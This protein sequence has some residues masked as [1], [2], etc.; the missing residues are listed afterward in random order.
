MRKF[1][2]GLG[3]LV[4]VMVTGGKCH[5][6]DGPWLVRDAP[7]RAMVTLGEAPKIPDAGVL[8]ELPEFGQT[9]ADLADVLLLNS[10]GQAQPLA[11]VWRGEGQTALLLAKALNP[12]E[13]YCVYFGGGTTRDMEKWEPKVSLLMETRRLPAN[14]K[15]DSRQDQRSPT[16]AGR[17]D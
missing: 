5:A 12:G 10:G 13:T 16:A 14:A 4:F 9:R 3:V 17:E 11:A 2:A 8:I 15:F 6:G 1:A 7:Y